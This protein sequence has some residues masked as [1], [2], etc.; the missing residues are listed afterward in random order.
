MEELLSLRG[1]APEFQLRADSCACSHFDWSRGDSVPYTPEERAGFADELTEK[2][3]RIFELGQSVSKAFVEIGYL[4]LEINNK[5]LIRFVCI[6]SQTF[7]DMGDYGFKVFGFQKSTT[8]NLM[9]IVKKFGDGEGG[10]SFAYKDY[11]YTQLVYLLPFTGYELKMFTPVATV[12]EIKELRA[13]LKKYPLHEWRSSDFGKKITW[14]SE[15]ERVRKAAAEEAVAEKKDKKEERKQGLLAMLSSAEASESEISLPSPQT[16]VADVSA[17]ELTEVASDSP[18]E[19]LIEVRKTLGLKNKE[20]R[21]KWVEGV[22]EDAS[23]YL[24]IPELDLK[25]YRYV[26]V[27]GA[28]LFRFNGVTYWDTWST[29]PGREGKIAKYFI[30]DSKCPKFDMCHARS[31]NQ[32]VDWLTEHG[33]EI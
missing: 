24:T 10:L 1:E 16:E 21:K 20:E 4:L 9:N 12:A 22:F 29:E 18:G 26:F 33:K 8:Y 3:E 13:G 5:N 17:E 28:R 19:K 23:P 32:V 27:N 25:I 15:L 2:T 14:R 31:V 11:S 30:T 6:K 7:L